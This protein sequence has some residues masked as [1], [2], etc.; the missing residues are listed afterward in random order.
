MY[1]RQEEKSAN[2]KTSVKPAPAK[3]VAGK[4]AAKKTATKKKETPLN[5][6]AL[7]AK[8][9]KAAMPKNISPMLATLVDKPFDEEGWQYEVKW[10]GYRAMAFI[11]KGKVDLL[12]RNNKSFNEKFY[13][14]HGALTG[15]EHNA[16]LDGEIAVLNL[17]LIHI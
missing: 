12:S 14:V 8:G 5:I 15:W 9:K 10:D 3:K 4:N 7:V 11:N 6:E 1:K 17:S 13:P 16:V 2:K